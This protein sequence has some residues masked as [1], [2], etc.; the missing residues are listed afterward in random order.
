MIKHRTMWLKREKNDLEQI[1]KRGIFSN[2]YF[3]LKLAWKIRKSVFV[4]MIFYAVSNASVV[5][6]NIMLPKLI[7]DEVI[8]HGSMKVILGILIG[9]SV[10]TILCRQI[11]FWS[12]NRFASEYIW[13]KTIILNGEKFMTIDYELTDD[14]SLMDLN[15]RA[16]EILMRADEGILGT[17]TTLVETFRYFFSVLLSITILSILSPLLVLFFVLVIGVGFFADQKG[18]VLKFQFMNAAASD[19]RKIDFLFTFMTDYANGK[20][21]RLFNMQ[22]FLNQKLKES[23]DSCLSYCKKS[24]NVNGVVGIITAFMEMIQEFGIYSYLI[25]HT[26]LKKLE[27]GNFFMYSTAAH[28]LCWNFRCFMQNVARLFYLSDGLD[29]IRDFF[30]LDNRQKKRQVQEN[31]MEIKLPEK[32]FTITFENVS[33]RYPNQTEDVLKDMNLSIPFGERLA[34]VGEN[35]AGKTTFIKV[36]MGLYKPTKGRVLINGIDIQNYPRKEYYRL[37]AP[38]FQ[39]IEM[40]AMSFAENISLKPMVK[41]DE[42]RIYKAIVLANLQ[43]K[44]KQLPKKIHTQVLKVFTSEGV[45]FSGGEKQRIAIAR[46]IYKDAP[47]IILDEPT[48][49][50]DPIA[51]QKLYQEFEQLVSGRSN[52]FISHRLASVMFCDKIMLLQQ[53]RVEEYGTH[54]ELIQL[55]KEYYSMYETQAKTFRNGGI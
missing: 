26:L 9:F 45:E 21:I 44:V 29:V 42:D 35:G 53:G 2:I 24:E 11:A 23:S 49:A 41:T 8:N 48:S 18:N 19:K 55:K 6:V 51:E 4:Y 17:I 16:N 31:K 32:G 36:L 33:F 46:A 37:F 39:D 40:Y 15:A 20:D 30:E 3:V 28:Q 47:F 13:F 12:Q 22:S 1:K 7:I 54:Q 38:V 50:L 10:L 34:V 52:V 14:P 27:I 43:E 5:F 25:Y